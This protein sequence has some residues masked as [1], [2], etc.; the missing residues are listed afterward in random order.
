LV[1]ALDEDSGKF[2]API[3]EPS[4][5][6]HAAEEMELMLLHVRWASGAGG[7]IAGQVRTILP[8]ADDALVG[9]AIEFVQTPDESGATYPWPRPDPQAALIARLVESGVLRAED[10]KHL[11]R[12][13]H[14]HALAAPDA[15]AVI[16]QRLSALRSGGPADART[17]ALDALTRIEDICG[18][19]ADGAGSLDVMIF[20]SE[21]AAEPG[22][23]PIGEHAVA[24]LNEAIEGVGDACGLGY[25]S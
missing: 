1:L 6:L 10:R 16:G 11:G 3:G 12:T 21:L 24:A 25:G 2:K 9:A 19:A 5:F 7:D 17:V 23:G 15:K 14:R 22:A 20:R 4:L 8:A 13:S 18:D